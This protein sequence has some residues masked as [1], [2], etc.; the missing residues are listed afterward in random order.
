[1]PALQY[2]V[3]AIP[4]ITT[5]TRLEPSPRDASLQKSLQAQ[6]RDPLWLLARQWQVG[7]FLGEDAG[8]P[9]HATLGVEMQTVTTY[10]P[11]TQESATVP[12]A[13]GVP[14]EVHVERETVALR[15]R[16]SVQHGLYFEN[17]V[18]QSAVASPE[19][20]I[21]AFRA[22][23]PI[24]AAVPDPTYATPDAARFR[25]LTAGRVT[26][27][28]ALYASAQAVAAGQTP[29][30]PLPME[31]ENVGMPAV[32]Q[33]FLAFRAALFSE[34]Q[35]DSAW[36]GQTLDY[37]FALGSP[38]GGQ[39]L[40]ANAADFPGGRLDWHSFSLAMAE[41]LPVF[42]ANP[43]T[44][45][46]A[47]F[48]FLPNHVTFR[49]MPEARWWNFEDATT[50]FGALDVETVDLA[51][52][53]VMEFALV[54]GNDWFSVP[55]PVTVGV[56]GAGPQGTLSRVT[57]LV[58]TDTFGVRTLIRPA[59]TTQV[60]PGETW[61]MYKLAG[62]G[63][64]SDFILMAPTL[65]VVSDAPALERV[66]FLRDDMAA[67]AWAVE[68]AL[69]GD[70][71]APVDAYQ[72]YLQRLAANPPPGPPAATPGG[73]PIYYTTEIPPPDN[74]IPMVPVQ[75]PTGALYLRR[76]IMESGSPIVSLQA[77][78][79]ILEPQ[80]PFFVVDRAV[81]RSGV[82]VQRYFRYTRGADG[83]SYLWLARKA[84]VGAG[85]GWSG[86]RFDVVRDTS[87][88]A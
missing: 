54:Y 79:A 44:V 84:G 7:E 67:M 81:P 87:R 52:L 53:L 63:V 24:P 12:I 50:D 39:N 10:R 69:Q 23:F 62:D 2:R 36:D 16:G 75:T 41:P 48:D 15:L 22:A 57:T 55:V 4:S 13:P 26:D 43:A 6:V 83:S 35:Q 42:A 27:R 17:L 65:G 5:W 80:H 56:G 71:D 64:R 74:W 9:V 78:A 33:A 38:A 73:A 76:G 85:S 40:L 88:T 25:A 59:E 14:V 66:N 21:A 30:A 11:G 86:L 29:A 58:V 47:S 1:L 72:M 31:A 49:G 3:E 51:K 8:S 61:S 34:P 70:L 19:T 32:L 28:E 46:P 45:T 77:R 68:S 18:R 20:V 60:V 37:D 82:Q